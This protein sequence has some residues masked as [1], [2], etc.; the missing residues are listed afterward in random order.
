M[1]CT[2]QL[3]IITAL[4][5]AHF[6]SCSSTKETSNQDISYEE[7][8]EV[9]KKKDTKKKEIK[10]KKKEY[11]DVQ[12][13]L[14]E[15]TEIVASPNTPISTEKV[16]TGDVITLKL[17]KAITRNRKV[18]APKGTT[19]KGKVVLSQNQKKLIGRSKLHL[20]LTAVELKGNSYAISTNTVKFDGKSNTGKTL[21]KAGA[22]AAAGAG[23]G[24][25]AG[26]DKGKSAG[27]GAAVGAA[28]GTGA[29]LLQKKDAIVIE[30]SIP[31]STT[32]ETKIVVQVTPY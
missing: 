28:V 31:F 22:G 10:E 15:G 32:S 3:L 11:I 2:K 4:L 20:E 9:T 18:I 29:A 8:P 1:Y 5:C 26:E 12:Y 24:A 17:D 30:E 14:R 19:L 7:L 13:I 25:L 21:A 6:F 16:K 27:I 23:V